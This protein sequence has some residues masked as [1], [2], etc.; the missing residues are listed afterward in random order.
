MWQERHSLKPAEFARVCT[1]FDL[2]AHTQRTRF[3]ECTRSPALLPSGNWR[4][5]V[6]RKKRYVA[7]TF[8]RRKDSE[9]WPLDPARVVL[10][11]LGLVRKSDGRDRRPTQDELDEL[12]DYFETNPGQVIPMGRIVRYAVATTMRQEEIL[13]EIRGVCV[14]PFS[15]WD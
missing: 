2:S 6:R 14:V 9:V 7:E 12:I 4:V 15:S 5:Q 13:P 1:R 3:G 11:Y 8:R 10:K